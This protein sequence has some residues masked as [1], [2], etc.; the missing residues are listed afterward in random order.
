MEWVV[1]VCEDCGAE[2]VAEVEYDE[3]G[4]VRGMEVGYVS[5][6]PWRKAPAE[7]KLRLVK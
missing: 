2:R 1:E 6:L 7:A 5:A 3:R 4:K